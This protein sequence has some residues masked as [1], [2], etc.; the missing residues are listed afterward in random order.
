MSDEGLGFVWEVDQVEV[1]PTRSWHHDQFGGA[2]GQVH[3]GDAVTGG[4]LG[5]APRA[6]AN[7]RSSAGGNSTTVMVGRAM[8]GGG[9]AFGSWRLG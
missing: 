8:A 3:R 7:S 9:S 6:L 5:E 2:I 1:D 4:Q